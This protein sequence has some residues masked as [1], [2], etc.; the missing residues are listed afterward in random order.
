MDLLENQLAVLIVV[1]ALTSL[2]LGLLVV[3]YFQTRSNRN[4]QLAHAERQAVL[5]QQLEV[6]RSELALLQSTLDASKQ[7]A[8][9]SERQAAVL[10]DRLAGQTD[11]LTQTQQTLLKTEAERSDLKA[12]LAKQLSAYSYLQTAT[13][14]KITLLNEIN[15]FRPRAENRW[16]CS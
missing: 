14:E 6:Q 5:D 9:D 12:E 15:A 2:V 10:H 11:S 3:V 8:N 7:A 16:N 4:Q 13:D 1:T